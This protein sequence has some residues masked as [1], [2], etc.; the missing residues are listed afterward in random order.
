MLPASSMLKAKNEACRVLSLTR[1][2]TRHIT[3]ASCYKF[4]LVGKVLLSLGEIWSW[5][6]GVTTEENLSRTRYRKE[7][8][9]YVIDIRLKNARQMFDARD[10]APFRERDLDDD[11]VRYF[12]TAAQEFSLKTPLKLVVEFTEETFES[13]DVA[14]LDQAIRLHF[15]YEADALR[16][17]LRSTFRSGR[18]FLLIGGL[19][20][21]GCVLVERY[22]RTFQ[23]PVEFESILREGPIIGVWVAMWRPIETFLYDWWPIRE[24]E[25]HFKKL[26]ASEIKIYS[27]KAP[28]PAT[29]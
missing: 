25:L 4:A 12:I 16:G 14:A 27:V 3:A 23:S 19:V 28:T 11:A 2:K 6:L 26:A 20:L 5:R 22:I 7:G 8:D 24:K 29:S 18:L 17:R 21:L 15:K 10:P 1:A 13:I 9:A